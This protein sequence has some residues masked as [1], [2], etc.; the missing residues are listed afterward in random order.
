V[1]D[2][3]AGVSGKALVTGVT[4]FIGANVARALLADGREIRV[5]VREGSD[6]RNVPKGDGVEV[7]EGDLRDGPRVAEAVKGCAEVYHV[8]ADYRFWAAD[9]KEIYD[10]NVEGTRHLL[11][12]AHRHEVSRFIHT[13]SVGTIGL[14]DQPNPCSEKTAYADGQFTSH[15]KKSKLQ[16][17]NLVLDHAKR[18]LPA[19]IVNPST[20]IG[21]WDRKPT[22]TGQIIVDFM[23]GQ[24]PA[25]VKTG[26]N[27]VHV[28]DVAQG[29][30]L[31]A[32]KGSIGERYI[33]GNEN[34]SMLDFL[35]MLGRLTNRRAPRIR[36]PYSVAFL[37]GA[38]STGYAHAI[39]KRAPKV[40]LEAVKMSK[41][42]MFFDS[43]KAIRELGL[44][45]TPVAVAAAD[46][47]EWFEENGYFARSGRDARPQ[48]ASS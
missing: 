14:S 27:F 9:P 30:L 41:R 36:I 1:G 34:L 6:R 13:S 8:A 38:A 5:L 25:Y 19:V 26:L 48:H 46:A 43:S 20:P 39:S 12:G 22:P 17:E 37:V 4:G 16:A 15:Y 11:E 28:K 35:S 31:A 33:L 23:T 40:P 10:S 2:A 32:K 18:G 21:P 7:F 3:E 47:L 44:P 24:L 29:H 42:F 45:Q